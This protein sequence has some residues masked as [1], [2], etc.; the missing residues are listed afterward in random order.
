MDRNII[1]LLNMT[2]N[3]Y[4][5]ELV[6]LASANTTPPPDGPKCDYVLDLTNE[7]RAA[8]FLYLPQE[9]WL[10]LF[11]LPLI[12]TLGVII[13]SLF[14][15]VIGS[16]KEMQT[17]TNFYLAN[18]AFAD[19]LF[20][21]VSIGQMVSQYV[22]S[23]IR[24]DWLRSGSS[25]GCCMLNFVVYHTYF[26]SIFLVTLIAIERFYA[27]CWPL[28]H[29]PITGKRRSLKLTAGTWAI[30]AVFAGLYLFRLAVFQLVC[31]RWPDKEEYWHLPEVMGTCTPLYAWTNIFSSLTL[32]IPFYIA[33]F[34]NC[35]LYYLI[36]RTLTIR[37]SDENELTAS[38]SSHAIDSVKVRNNI[39][40]MLIVNGVVF[41]V[42]QAP[43]QSTA[44]G[45]AIVD[46]VRDEPVLNYKQYLIWTW[47]AAILLYFNSVVNPVIYNVMS[48]R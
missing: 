11:L 42:C 35:I 14:L 23:P 29:R 8:A 36:V 46:V 16:L 33:F 5:R 18:L 26:A 47:T 24:R 4:F 19:V 12:L 20:L 39:A 28:K 6:V 44:F 10:Y 25:I 2:I 48:S 31:L 7:E 45:S 27:V 1:S 43:F 41:F 15:F 37:T 22:Y 34:V 38:S 21:S 9:K 32:V 40:K 3:M 13:N 17:S 30:A